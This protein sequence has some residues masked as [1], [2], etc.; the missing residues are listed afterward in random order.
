MMNDKAKALSRSQFVHT[1]NEDVR[2]QVDYY[3]ENH[4][5]YGHCLD[6]FLYI[7]DDGSILT[8]LP[9]GKEPLKFHCYWNITDEEINKLWEGEYD[10][11][12]NR[13]LSDEAYPAYLDFVSGNCSCEVEA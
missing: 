3:E 1:V 6:L 13:F 9:H 10:E 2:Y 4:V 7:N 11:E 5:D 8:D 12:F